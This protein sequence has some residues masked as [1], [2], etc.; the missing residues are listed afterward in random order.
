MYFI[1]PGHHGGKH[2]PINRA[3]GTNDCDR[4]KGGYPCG[5]GQATCRHVFYG[6]RSYGMQ[7]ASR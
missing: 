6:A 4:N 1:F 2:A 7:Q 3:G 5:V